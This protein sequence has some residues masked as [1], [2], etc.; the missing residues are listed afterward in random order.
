MLHH[1][2]QAYAGKADMLTLTPQVRFQHYND[3]VQFNT[4]GIL[5]ALY[6]VIKYI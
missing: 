1:W 5:T 2:W 3:K 4:F 6:I